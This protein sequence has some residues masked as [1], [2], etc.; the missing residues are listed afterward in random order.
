MA[1]KSP[2][3]HKTLGV[4]SIKKNQQVAKSSPKKTLFINEL[5]NKKQNHN[6]DQ[7]QD[8]AGLFFFKFPK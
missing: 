7:V 8:F 1:K 6:K 2:Q 4:C 3:N 5:V